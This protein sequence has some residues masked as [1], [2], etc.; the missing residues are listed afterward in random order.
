MGAAGEN[1]RCAPRSKLSAADRAPP[2]CSDVEEAELLKAEGLTR[3]LM[4]P[5]PLAPHA[6]ADG[7]RLPPSRAPQAAYPLAGRLAATASRHAVEL[8]PPLAA[9]PPMAARPPPLPPSDGARPC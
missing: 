2:P 4:A 6:E 9:P 3:S 1:G 8:V 5:G 7:G